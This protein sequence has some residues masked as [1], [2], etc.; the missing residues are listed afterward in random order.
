MTH[1]N[2]CINTKKIV[3]VTAATNVSRARCLLRL[4]KQPDEAKRRS[5]T[6]NVLFTL[7]VK[8]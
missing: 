5:D 7:R 8:V 3:L 6:L 2:F 4:S 1:E